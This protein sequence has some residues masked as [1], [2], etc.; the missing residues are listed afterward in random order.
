MTTEFLEATLRI[1]KKIPTILVKNGKLRIDTEHG[2]VYP[3]LRDFQEEEI[4]EVFNRVFPNL[5]AFQNTFHKSWET[6][7]DTPQEE[8]WA[9]AVIHYFTTYGLESLGIDNEGMVYIPDE[10]DCTPELRKFRVISTISNE[11]LQKVVMDNITSGIALKQKTVE[12][13][14]LIAKEIGLEIPIDKVVNKEVKTILTIKFGI[15]PKNGEELVRVINYTITDNTMLIKNRDTFFAIKN[16]CYATPEK[17]NYVAKLLTEGKKQAASVFY[18][19]RPIFYALRKAGFKKEVNKI[20][21]LA[22][23]YWQPKPEAQFLSTRILN[24]YRLTSKDLENLPVFELVKIYNKLSYV[25]LALET[26]GCYNDI[27]TVRS[28]SLFIKQIPKAVSCEYAFS[29]HEAKDLLKQT[30]KT[31]SLAK[32]YLV[33]PE[34]LDLAYPT[35]EKSFIGDLPLYTQCHCGQSST[36]GIAWD[37]DDLDLSGLLQDGTKVG[38]NSGYS[39]KDK[40]VLYSGDCTRG[41]AEALYFKTDQKALIM[42]NVYYGDICKVDLFITKEEDF[43]EPDN[44]WS[45]RTN[46][47][48]DPNQVVYSVKLDIEKQSKVLGLYEK[49]KDQTIFTFVDLALMR[50]RVSNN[51]DL[52]SIAMDNISLQGK[53]SLKLSD[54]YEVFSPEDYELTLS[55]ME[56][57]DDSETRIQEFTEKVLDMRD[58]NKVSILEIANGLPKEQNGQ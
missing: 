5:K 28:G 27:I 48:L 54:I 17:R 43:Q 45:S 18:R 41:G 19:Y 56:E 4:L 32:R 20:S 9:Q 23:Y 16:A 15:V 13:L 30:I 12:D 6:I 40:G 31:R 2:L 8:L 29:I 44:Q 7:I 38:W 26:Y 57:E 22:A 25:L 33:L 37:D 58:Y 36:I 35:S 3:L 34:G 1:T 10:I 14:L 47:I 11:E 42:E 39:S 50:G 21:R 24:G 51:N 53:S 49:E 46:Y 55:R 52:V